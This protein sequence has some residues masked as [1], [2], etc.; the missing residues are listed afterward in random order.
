MRLSNKHTTVYV[1][2]GT[3]SDAKFLVWHCED[4]QGAERHARKMRDAYPGMVF[5]QV[6]KIE[7]ALPKETVP[8]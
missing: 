6:H 4:E 3:W 7:Q 1:I 5:A 2:V 8:R